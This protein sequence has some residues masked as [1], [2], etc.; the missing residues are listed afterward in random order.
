MAHRHIEDTESP[1]TPTSFMPITHNIVSGASKVT[2]SAAVYTEKASE[3]VARA[4]ISVGEKIATLFEAA[5]EIGEGF[6]FSFYYNQFTIPRPDRA[7]NRMG[8]LGS[9]VAA[10]T[11]EVV[12]HDHGDEAAGLTGQ[13]GEAVADT[14]KATRNVVL[15]V[16]HPLP[17]RSLILTKIFLFCRHRWRWAKVSMSRLGRRKQTKSTQS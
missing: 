13:A 7:V 5:G 16:S 12:R 17:T 11:Q 4:S 15:G 1:E 14:A 9:T 6:V 10:S 2:S 8:H 3:M